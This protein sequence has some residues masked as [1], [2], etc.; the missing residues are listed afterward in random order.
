MSYCP[1]LSGFA[2]DNTQFFPFPQPYG[3]KSA[4]LLYFCIYDTS[5]RKHQLS[6][7]L[8][9]SNAQ[10]VSQAAFVKT[11]PRRSNS[12]CSGQLFS[13]EVCHVIKPLQYRTSFCWNGTFPCSLVRIKIG[14]KKFEGYKRKKLRYNQLT[15]SEIS[16]LPKIHNQRWRRW[17]ICCSD[18]GTQNDW[19]SPSNKPT[20]WKK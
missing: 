18:R 14:K 2:V 8:F 15:C 17:N 9:A 4:A 13:L 11:V 20:K 3:I 10:L 19:A 5:V 12:V 7:I 16:K 1:I 6:T